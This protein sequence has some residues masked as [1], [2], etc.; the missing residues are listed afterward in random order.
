[1]VQSIPRFSNALR[2]RTLLLLLAILPPLLW[3]GW[4]KYQAW[5]AERERQKA[6]RDW[7]GPAVPLTQSTLELPQ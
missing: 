1:V 6:L 2:L 7:T 5:K 3:I 4:R